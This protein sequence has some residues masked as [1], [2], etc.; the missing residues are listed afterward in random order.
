M[1]CKSEYEAQPMANTSIPFSSTHSFIHSR[2][3]YSASSSPLLLR[4]APDY[5]IGTLSELTCR[6]ATGNREWRTCPTCNPP[7]ARHRTYHWAITHTYT[8][9]YI[10]IHTYTHSYIHPF[11][12]SYIHNYT[13]SYVNYGQF[14]NGVTNW[15]RGEANKISTRVRC[16][17][18][19]GGRL[20]T[21]V[22]SLRKPIG[23]SGSSCSSSQLL[24]GL[25]LFAEY[26]SEWALQPAL[27]LRLF[28]QRVL[29][30]MYAAQL[31]G[32]AVRTVQRSNRNIY[33]KKI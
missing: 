1:V 25:L 6:S 10:H 31:A 27:L 4:G 18:D 3:L 32:Y 11:I 14:F 26:A 28:M 19:I 24:L 33:N 21:E 2:Y 29:A 12:H 5:S 13:H 23:S 16:A 22:V 7:D 20:N 17:D 9:S 30:G 8:H 15:S